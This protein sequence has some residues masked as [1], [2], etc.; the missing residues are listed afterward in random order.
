MAFCGLELVWID[1]FCPETQY[2]Y[3]FPGTFSML[4]QYSFIIH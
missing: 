2:A 3:F 4:I 1:D